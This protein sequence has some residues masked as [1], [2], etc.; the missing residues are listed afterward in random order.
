MLINLTMFV[1]FYGLIIG[2]ISLVARGFFKYKKAKVQWMGQERTIYFY[3]KEN[4]RPGRMSYEY[5]LADPHLLYFSSYSFITLSVDNG[6]VGY[7]YMTGSGLNRFARKSWLREL[8]LKIPA[9]VG[10]EEAVTMVHRNTSYNEDKKK[11]VLNGFIYPE[12]K[13]MQEI[14]SQLPQPALEQSSEDFIQKLPE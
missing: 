13:V 10:I 12:R 5:Y 8:M 9:A 6:Q 7:V 3:V 14:I 2:L 11:S 4:I 1:V